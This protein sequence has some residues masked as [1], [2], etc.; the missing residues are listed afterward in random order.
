MSVHNNSKYL[1]LRKLLTMILILIKILM[2]PTQI[3][4]IEFY[5]MKLS[6]GPTGPRIHSKLICI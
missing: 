1:T 6:T 5:S 2:N 3:Y 4:T